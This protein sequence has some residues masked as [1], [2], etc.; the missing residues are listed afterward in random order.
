MPAKSGENKEHKSNLGNTGVKRD[1]KL[2]V[3][4]E[5]SRREQPLEGS[6]TILRGGEDPVS[7]KTRSPKDR[8]KEKLERWGK[9][10]GAGGIIS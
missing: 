1:R 8:N 9:P 10:D 4:K 7:T 5:K 6:W 2:G 3:R